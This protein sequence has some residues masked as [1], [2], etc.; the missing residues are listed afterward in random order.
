[1]YV[2]LNFLNKLRE[3]DEILSQLNKFITVNNFMFLRHQH[4]ATLKVTYSRSLILAVINLMSFKVRKRA[5][6]RNRYNQ[7]LYQWE[8]YYQFSLGLLL[9]ERICSL[10]GA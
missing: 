4:L 1:M 10:L 9:K 5:K 7:A 6:S 2:L 8:R 3:R